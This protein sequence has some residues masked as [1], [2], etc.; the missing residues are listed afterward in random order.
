MSDDLDFVRNAVE[1][2]CSLILSKIL[3]YLKVLGMG[4]TAMNKSHKSLPFSS[5]HS[6]GKRQYL[7]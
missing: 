2:I 6:S 1:L 7:K 4:D 5:S 3:S